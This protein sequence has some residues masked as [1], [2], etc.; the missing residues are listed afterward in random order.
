MAPSLASAEAAYIQAG[1]RLQTACSLLER[2]L[3]PVAQTDG[4]DTEGPPILWPTR[5]VATH[6]CER[7]AAELAELDAE[8]QEGHACTHGRDQTGDGRNGANG[9][10]QPPARSSRGKGK[11][12]NAGVIQ[13]EINALESKFDAYTVATATVCSL[14]TEETDRR[15]YEEDLANW[16]EYY[17][18]IKDR[19]MD[20]ISLLNTPGQAISDHQ[21]TT[22]SFGGPGTSA[23][24]GG[25]ANGAAPVQG[26]SGVRGSLLGDSHLEQ[27]ESTRGNETSGGLVNGLNL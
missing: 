23:Q 21:L 3:P 7:C 5:R 15:Q 20:V 10:W 9:V 6:A 27:T 13:Q 17:G 11:Q 12:P 18:I 24:L 25:H 1:Y 22:F 14:S 8:E 2:H 19:A 16:T 26:A 4:E